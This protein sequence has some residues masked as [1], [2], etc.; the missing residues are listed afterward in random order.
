MSPDTG[1]SMIAIINASIVQGSSIGPTAYDV[2]ASSSRSLY[3]L[4]L[5]R[6]QGLP[7]PVLHIVMTATTIARPMYA[8]PALECP[9]TQ[10]KNE[11]WKYHNGQ[12]PES[13]FC[14]C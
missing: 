8:S 6:A 2:G 7:S 3:A 14:P 4:R 9:K 12:P 10:E 13:F 5:L 1:D 11:K